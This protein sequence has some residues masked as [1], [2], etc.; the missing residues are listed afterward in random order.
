MAGLISNI[1]K[2][3]SSLFTGRKR[4]KKQLQSY[5]KKI[6]LLLA[7]TSYCEMKISKRKG[8]EEWVV[9]ATDFADAFTF[10]S[11]MVKLADDY[12]HF[13]HLSIQKKHRKIAVIKFD[14]GLENI[15]DMTIHFISR[16]GVP[17]V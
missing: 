3:L 7:S 17:K 9:K 2:K 4:K 15:H 5:C 13:K 12:Q 16:E 11:R 14:P 1:L 6:E 10:F 8:K